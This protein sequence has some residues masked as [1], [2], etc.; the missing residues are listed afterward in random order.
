MVEM[1]AAFSARRVFYVVS[2]LLVWQAVCSAGLVSPIIL[3]SPLAILLAVRTSGLDYL[4]AIP[5]TLFEVVL[6]ISA[7]WICG[8]AVGLLVGMSRLFSAAIAPILSA[9]FAMPLIVWYPI[10][11]IWFGLG[12][13]SKIVFGAVGGF[14]PIALNTVTAAQTFDR[15]FIT[16]GRSIGASGLQL[17]WKFVLPLLLPHI[18]S[19]LRIGTSFVVIG[20]LVSEMIASSDGIGFWISTNRTLFNTG[21]V[22]LGIVLA[23]GACMLMNWMLT[24]LERKAGAWRDAELVA[25]GR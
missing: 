9:I 15:R 13:E 2:F 17:F 12:P 22:Y 14:F 18:I 24:A 11:L 21:D 4:S 19:G 16:L 25:S 3:A 5:V 7:A 10:M 1:A 20:I 23:L 8:I 6:G